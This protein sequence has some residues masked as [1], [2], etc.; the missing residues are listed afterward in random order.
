MLGPSASTRDN[1]RSFYRGVGD[2]ASVL[3]DYE[4]AANAYDAAQRL[5]YSGGDTAAAASAMHRLGRVRWRQ[6]RVDAARVAFE[7]ALELLGAVE[8]SDMAETLLQLADLHATSLGRTSDGLVYAERALAIVER[9]GDRRLTAE[10]CYVIGNVRARGND[11]AAGRTSLERALGLAQDLD[12]PALGAEI[13]G[14]LA[15][16]YAW[17]GEFDRS[18]EVSVLRAELA[19]RTQDP[20]LLRHVYAWLAFNDTQRGRWDEAERLYAVQAEHVDSLASPEPRANLRAYRGLQRYFQ[21][22]FADAERDL[23]EAVELLR[24]TGSGTLLWHLG[25]FGLVLAE[26]D[27][28]DEAGA[29]FEELHTL[30]DALDGGSRAR[31]FAFAHLAVGYA[32][33]GMREQAAGCYDKLLP[34][35]GMVSPIL[36][37]RGLAVA[38]VASGDLTV[39]RQHFVDAEEAARKMDLRPELALTLLQHGALERAVRVRDEGLQLCEELGMQELG[40]RTLEWLAGWPRGTRGAARQCRRTDRSR[41]RGAVPGC[42]GTDQPGHRGSARLEREN[43]CAPPDDD[44]LQDR[45]RKPRWRSSLRAEARSGLEGRPKVSGAD[46]AL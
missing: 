42:A 6:E 13:C 46:I 10:A 17:S 3:G 31:G 9:L 32:R 7:R 22:R 18:R 12:E 21:G 24:P 39:A 1:E 15:N 5:W 8:S 26:L 27:R 28:P 33:L 2:A 40:Q 45:C 41:G 29:C 25:R 38:A 16:V 23:R 37:D 19:Q 20:F 43:R 30:A 11:L 14:Y 44:L 35:R 36:V 4:R 34:F